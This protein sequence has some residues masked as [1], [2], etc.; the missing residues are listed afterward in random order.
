MLGHWNAAQVRHLRPP[1]TFLR[2]A[3]RL[4]LEEISAEHE[5][6]QL[7]DT[8]GLN[9]KI[10]TYEFKD[11]IIPGSPHSKSR[12]PIVFISNVDPT[13]YFQDK[14]F[15]GALYHEAERLNSQVLNFSHVWILAVLNFEGIQINS[16]VAPKRPIYRFGRYRIIALS[17][18]AEPKLRPDIRPNIRCDLV[19]YFWGYETFPSSDF[20]NFYEVTYPN[21]SKLVKKYSLTQREQCS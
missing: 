11:G 16:R 20:F 7:P 10:N 15:F 6:L 17:D 2:L 19:T 9:P 13:D 21:L 8:T 5:R 3:S 14:E 18:S 4:T 1:R 12:F